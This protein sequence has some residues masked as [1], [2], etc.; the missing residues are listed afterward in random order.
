MSSESKRRFAEFESL[1]AN[2]PRFW[3]NRYRHRFSV[4]HP[5]VK[6]CE[7]TRVST[8]RLRVRTCSGNSCFRAEGAAKSLVF[9]RTKTIRSHRS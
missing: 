1:N 8:V 9:E 6:Y 7:V 2:D 4:C 5:T 3:P